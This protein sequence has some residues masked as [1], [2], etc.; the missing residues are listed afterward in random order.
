[1]R[2]KDMTILDEMTVDFTTA[3]MTFLAEVLSVTTED[4][5]YGLKE[6]ERRTASVRCEINPDVAR[7]ILYEV[8]ALHKDDLDE[9]AETLYAHHESN[10]TLDEKTRRVHAI[11]QGL[12]KTLNSSLDEY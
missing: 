7:D 9:Y 1:M 2:T 10:L 12:V 5:P 11:V 8:N 4:G 3:G 6:V